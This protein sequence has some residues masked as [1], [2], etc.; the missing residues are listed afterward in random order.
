MWHGHFF[1]YFLINICTDNSKCGIVISFIK[2]SSTIYWKESLG[3]P[4]FQNIVD[5]KINERYNDA[6]FKIFV[7]VDEKLMKKMTI[8]HLDSDFFLS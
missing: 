4:W 1:H 3:S 6:T 2:F 7:I 8:P 5:E